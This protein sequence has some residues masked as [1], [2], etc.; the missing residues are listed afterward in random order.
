MQIS[1][2]L[3]GALRDLLPP[4]KKGR[5][6]LDLPDGSILDELLASLAIRGRFSVSINDE[7]VNDR[8]RPLNDGDEI[9]IF[10]SAAG[11]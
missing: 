3:L 10:R 7:I 4:E 6:L 11:G 1:L 9:I 5:D 8:S 2:R